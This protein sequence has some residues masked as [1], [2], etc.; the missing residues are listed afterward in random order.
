MAATVRDA[1]ALLHESASHDAII[2][3]DR[4]SERD[5]QYALA[6][7]RAD[8]DAGRL[9][10]LLIASQAKQ[11]DMTLN[12]QRTRN[13]FVLP[14]PMAT[15][16]P[17]L[18]RKLEDAIKFAAAP[19]SL[20][21]APEEQQI[22]LRYEVR[23]TKGQALSEP[24]RKQFAR[25]SLDWFAQMARGELPGYDLLPAKYA[26]LH[27]LNNEETAPQ[28]LRI[29]ARYGTVEAQQRLAAILLDQKRAAIHVLAAQELN[30][31]I[32]RNGLVLNSDQ[33]SLLRRLEQ[34]PEVPPALQV[35]LSILLGACG[36]RPA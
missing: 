12:A 8:Q 1:I 7:F 30:R 33:I 19:E 3:D 24:E 10:V 18:K 15:S 2:I 32:Q 29:I 26:L 34:Q 4:V 20:R 9:P 5:L 35:E 16:A 13:A 23:R 22:W 17:E 31:N 28:A 6:Q 25:D 11:T 27:A 14:E 36:R 21:H